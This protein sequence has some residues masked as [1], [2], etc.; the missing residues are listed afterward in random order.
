MYFIKTQLRIKISLIWTMWPLC[1]I[2]VSFL[3]CHPSTGPVVSCTKW[4]CGRDGGCS[5]LMTRTF[6]QPCSF[7]QLAA[8][9]PKS[10]QQ[11]ATLSLHHDTFLG[12]KMS[13]GFFWKAKQ[14][15]VTRPFFI[16]RVFLLFGV[17]MFSIWLHNGRKYQGLFLFLLVCFFMFIL[18]KI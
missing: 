3:L 11:R 7:S 9:S 16:L 4:S 2:S 6:S 8:E 14:I 12:S 10:H 15:Y 17:K 18:G 5:G 1:W 13:K